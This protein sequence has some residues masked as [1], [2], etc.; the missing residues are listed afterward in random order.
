ME[1][2]SQDPTTM[3]STAIEAHSSELQ[4]F[5]SPV[6]I[7]IL[8]TAVLWFWMY[9]TRLPAMQRANI[10]PDDA[11]HPGRWGD[12]LPANIRAV[13]DNY[14]HLH[15][16][17]TIFYA[18]MGFAALTGGADELMLKLA[19]GYVGIRVVHSLVQ[20]LSPNVTQRFVVFALAS[21]VLIA[22]SVKEAIR[23]FL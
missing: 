6:L 18:L 5:L 1:N 15:E 9:A 3:I 22:M 2:E 21:I 4:S 16:Q 14:N 7:L 17:P 13:A 12:R 8:W 10:N 20:I 11:R 19:Y 23:V